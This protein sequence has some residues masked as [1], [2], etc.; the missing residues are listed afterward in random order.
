MNNYSCNV[1]VFEFFIFD[2][3]MFCLGKLKSFVIVVLCDEPYVLGNNPSIYFFAYENHET[4]VNYEMNQEM[5]L[6][7]LLEG[8]LLLANAL[9][10]LNEDRFLARRGWSFEEYSGIKRNSLKGRILGLIYA[11]QYLRVPLMLL[12]ILCII[13][14]LISG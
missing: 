3:N 11:T 5:G 2:N 10:I 4:C 12:N 6:W 9:A 13:V 1:S 7:T 8:C 14:K